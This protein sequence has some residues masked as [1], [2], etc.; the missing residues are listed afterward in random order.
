HRQIDAR[1]V[2]TDV[3]GSERRPA[4]ADTGLQT[5]VIL[6]PLIHCLFVALWRPCWLFPLCV[7]VRE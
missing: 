5:K 3:A 6:V 4:K 7:C 2:R 1:A